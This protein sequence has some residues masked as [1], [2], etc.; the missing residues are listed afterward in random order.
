MRRW[1]LRILAAVIGVLVL[2]ALAGTTWQWLATRRVIHIHDSA[3]EV[4]TSRRRLTIP[5]VVITG[6]RGA[7]ATWQGLQRDQASL[8]DAGCQIV[9]KQSGHVLGSISRR[10]S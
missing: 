4:R 6:A 10:L 8:S 3:S 1:A 2:A 5:V 9:A 7:D